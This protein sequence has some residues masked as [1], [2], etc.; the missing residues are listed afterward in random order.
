MTT[1]AQAKRDRADFLFLRAAQM[2]RLK[3]KKAGMTQNADDH[4][5]RMLI[6]RDSQLRKYS[7]SEILFII[8]KMK[9]FES[10]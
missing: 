7:G 10:W 6:Q 4:D 9:N 5:V 1:R 2:L 8:R 3:M